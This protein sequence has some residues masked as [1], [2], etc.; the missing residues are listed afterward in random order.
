MGSWLFSLPTPMQKLIMGEGN[1]NKK[2]ND[3]TTNRDAY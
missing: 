1:G 2:M 3:V